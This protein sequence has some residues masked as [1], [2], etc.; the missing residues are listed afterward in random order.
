[1]VRNTESAIVCSYRLKWQI[2]LCT[3]VAV[4]LMGTAM[5]QDRPTGR[6]T[7]VASPA[8]DIDIKPI[9]NPLPIEFGGKEIRTIYIFEG[10]QATKS[11]DPARV[12]CYHGLDLALVPRE[13]V[14]R[15][16]CLGGRRIPAR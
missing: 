7:D 12:V 1:M 5:A 13:A 4:Q 11:S 10:R 3:V 16:P 15:L 6:P 8:D 9:G 14:S 2:A